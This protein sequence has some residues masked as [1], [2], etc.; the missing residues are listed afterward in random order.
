MSHVQYI[1]FQ[2]KF[3]HTVKRGISVS[4]STFVLLSHSDSAFALLF[5]CAVF[6]KLLHS[7]SQGLYCDLPNLKNVLRHGTSTHFEF[8]AP[9]SRSISSV[10]VQL[11]ICNLIF[12]LFFCTLCCL[13]FFFLCMFIFLFG[14]W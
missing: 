14:L 7:Q 13:C 11:L 10:S 9:P 6:T 2:L 5:G 4:F 12:G 3:L 8:N 1:T